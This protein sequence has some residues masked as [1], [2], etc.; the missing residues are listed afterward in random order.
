[1]IRSLFYAN[2]LKNTDT[3]F[4]TGTQERYYRNRIA[5]AIQCG[6]Y[7]TRHRRFHTYL[8]H[9]TGTGVSGNTYPEG[10]A[11]P[12]RIQVCTDMERWDL[13]GMSWAD[14]KSGERR[15]KVFLPFSPHFFLTSFCTLTHPALPAQ[16]TLLCWGSF[17]HDYKNRWLMS[18]LGSILTI[19]PQK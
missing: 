10:Y 8:L 1:M 13:N 3:V 9:V 19:H 14:A 15:K 2:V 5:V 11:L 4:L 12:S 17:H 18:Q 16:L 6:S 7:N